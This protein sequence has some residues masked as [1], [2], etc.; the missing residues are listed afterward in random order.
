MDAIIKHSLLLLAIFIAHIILLYANVHIS[1][2][3]NY[4]DDILLLPIV[5]GTALFIQRKW[6]AKQ[7]QFV[8]NK[9]IIAAAWLYFCVMFEMVIPPLHKGFTADWL[10]CIA[11]GLG[12]C[13]FY[14]F[15]NK[16]SAKQ[17][18]KF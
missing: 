2:I 3:D 17:Q 15:M 18:A 7:H 16:P 14:V 9:V 10:D 12:T 8:F 6:I 1:L 5:L 4:L 13:Y 11:Y